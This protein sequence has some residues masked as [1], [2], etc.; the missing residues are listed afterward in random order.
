MTK[1][2][3]L[4][5]LKPVILIELSIRA[6]LKDF[7]A[8]QNRFST[9]YSTFKV[10]S[11]TQLKFSLRAPQGVHRGGGVGLSWHS[12][13]LSYERRGLHS[14][15]P[16]DMPGAEN[17]GNEQ[18]PSAAGSL[19]RRPVSCFCSRQLMMGSFVRQMDCLC[20]ELIPHNPQRLQCCC[21][22]YKSFLC[23][24]ACLDGIF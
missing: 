3:N 9:L 23:R 11:N 10:F 24:P 19:I 12:P 4:H 13:L 7:D 21:G 17:E 2:E 20:E 14:W 22:C 1:N 16:W 15:P 5:C 18:D 8:V 6:V